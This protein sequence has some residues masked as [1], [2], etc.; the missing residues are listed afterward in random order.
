LCVIAAAFSPDTIFAFLLNSS[1]AIILFVYL[2]I[3]ISHVV[4]RSRT[5]DDQL[6][7]KMWLFPV[8][9]VLTGIAIVAILVQMFFQADL[10]SQLILSLLSWGSVIVFF[11][12]NRW[13]LGH[14][15]KLPGVPATTVPHRVLVLANDSVGTDELH[16]ALR[17]IGVDRDTVFQVVVPVSPIETGVA[18]THGPLDVVDA[19]RAAAE[20]RLAQMIAMLRAEN[21]TAVGVLGD[22]RPLDALSTAFESFRPESIVI[23][24]PPPEESIWHAFDV[25]DRARTDYPV[26]VTHVVCHANPALPPCT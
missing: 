25:V 16:E 10:R 23:A 12:A 22:S 24:T 7:V 5:P 21:L 15:S 2:L 26:P 17:E 20:N 1:G 6:K 18:Q 13:F 8:L 3:V 9:S 11:V 14:R 4:L 19:T